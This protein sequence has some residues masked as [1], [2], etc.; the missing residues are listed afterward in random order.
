MQLIA[1]RSRGACGLSHL[2]SGQVVE[3]CKLSFLQRIQTVSSLHFL[4][5]IHE[6]SLVTLMRDLRLPSE[7]MGLE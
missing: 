3:Y 1:E 2:I 4:R 6:H 7:A 5:D